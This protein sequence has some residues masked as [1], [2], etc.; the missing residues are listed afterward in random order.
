MIAQT[1]PIKPYKLDAAR[2]GQTDV[3]P[4][5]HVVEA[6]VQKTQAD[7]KLRVLYVKSTASS[8][9][10]SP[11]PFVTTKF[12]SRREDERD[13]LTAPR[14]VARGQHG[15]ATERMDRL[16][17]PMQNLPGAQ[18]SVRQASRSITD[19]CASSNTQLF[20]LPCTHELLWQLKQLEAEQQAQRTAQQQPSLASHA[21]SHSPKP[22]PVPP[23]KL[24]PEKKPVSDSSAMPTLKPSGSQTE[25]SRSRG[26]HRGQQTAAPSAAASSPTTPLHSETS[27]EE[28]LEQSSPGTTKMTAKSTRRQLR[29]EGTR[30]NVK[31]AKTVQRTPYKQWEQNISS[32][33]GLFFPE[34]S[35]KPGPRSGQSS[36]RTKST[37]TPDKVPSSLIHSPEPPVRTGPAEN[38]DKPNAT[39]VS[40][41]R[42]NSQ[43]SLD[44]SVLPEVDLELPQQTVAENHLP[45]DV[46]SEDP[47]PKTPASDRSHPSAEVPLGP[48]DT[49]TRTDS[50]PVS[51]RREP[52]GAQPVPRRSIWRRPETPPAT[53]V[54]A[55]RPPST[56]DQAPQTD[57]Q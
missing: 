16:V 1:K 6:A 17:R 55:Q 49:P 50:I 33:Q 44:L 34:S 37:V 28:S 20:G 38:P 29:Q 48:A 4:W 31:D 32:L 45:N 12:T 3:T 27:T 46:P 43:N 18:Q 57:S 54:P 21:T 40:P 15:Q 5:R 22:L 36:V 10:Q 41:R 14:K 53:P 24:T 30:R 47:S 39:A 9:E 52:L 42:P 7:G 23:L 8:A 11:Q 26:G 13:R 2:P 56:P 25:R 35:P 51:P 19:L